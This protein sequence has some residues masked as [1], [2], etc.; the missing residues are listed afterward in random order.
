MAEFHKVGTI[1][2]PLITTYK[3]IFGSDRSPRSDNVCLRAL[4]EHKESNKLALSEHSEHLNQIEA[5]EY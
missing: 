4:G 3:G 5:F 2:I 1:I